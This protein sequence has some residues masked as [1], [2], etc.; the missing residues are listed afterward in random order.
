MKR[1]DFDWQTF[2]DALPKW[3]DVPKEDRWTFI[4]MDQYVQSDVPET[5]EAAYHREKK[6]LRTDDV[7][8]GR[9]INPQMKTFW[10][11]M[12]H[13]YAVPYFP[14]MKAGG[15]RIRS[16]LGDVF[17]RRELAEFGGPSIRSYAPYEDGLDE[18]LSS[19][20]WVQEF[21]DCDDAAE[22]ERARLLE[23]E[24]RYFTS[25]SS[26]ELGQQL[27]RQLMTQAEPVRLRDLEIGHNDASPA[28][29]S[30]ALQAC[31]R[32]A[33]VIPTLHG[34]TLDPQVGLWPDVVRLLNRQ[35][36]S[37]PPGVQPLHTFHAATLMDDMTSML[38]ECMT[39]KV[40]LR[41][42]DYEIFKRHRERIEEDFAPFPEWVR[43]LL[44]E[45]LRDRLGKARR[46]LLKA[47]LVETK[48]V[49]GEDLRLEATPKGRD[50]L[51]LPPKERLMH[52][53]D[54]MRTKPAGDDPYY[55]Q[56]GELEF[57]PDW[58]GI[59]ESDIVDAIAQAF[60]R[61][62]EEGF[63][64]YG[65][66]I[67][68]NSRENNPFRQLSNAELRKLRGRYRYIGR[69][70]TQE[71]REE[72]YTTC[73]NALMS[74]RLIGLG[75]VT[76]GVDE[77]WQLAFA[78]EAPGRYLLG[79]A[80]DFEYGVE[81]TA[82]VVVQPNFEITFLAPSPS[83]ESAIGRFAE[84]VGQRVG[85]LFKITRESVFQAAA[86]GMEAQQALDVLREVSSQPVP[87]NVEREIK[88]WFGRCHH[89]NAR[90]ALLVECPD[91]ATAAR[92]VSA[93]GKDA[94]RLTDTTVELPRGK[95]KAKLQRQLRKE[96][97][98]MH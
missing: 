67:R 73:L 12:R 25:T 30:E 79:L 56:D 78:L 23:D 62:G 74:Q 21:L 75:G 58:G 55:S 17:T 84:R 70:W 52:L 60:Q 38:V 43:K 2:L 82:E 80:D 90:E 39:D 85:V 27:V 51:Q 13:F 45:P 6:V 18:Y 33:L 7:P 11:C 19:P 72:F 50:W 97:L 28:V 88:G 61:T 91:R 8:T 77:D 47:D 44:D 65:D 10:R 63:V 5:L 64:R 36:A 68:Y 76:I 93:A 41:S 15:M 32:Y 31:V 92:L 34:E 94:R 57:I 49:A 83:T 3:E 71:E 40:R 42:N 20:E 86:S 81:Q 22:W 46:H 53:F 16:Y 24:T 98:F 26:F 4:E 54:A 69:R 96:G 89:L 59:L 9:R 35:P 66:F 48:G 14:D 37:P 1:F 29:V 87:D 95:K